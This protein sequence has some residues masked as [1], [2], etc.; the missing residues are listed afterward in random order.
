MKGVKGR[1]G[2]DSSWELLFSFCPIPR[3]PSTPLPLAF[4]FPARTGVAPASLLW[5]SAY[6]ELWARHPQKLPCGCGSREGGLK[7]G[8]D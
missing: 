7:A 2:E 8:A 5:G 1:K 6:A 4:S 3:G